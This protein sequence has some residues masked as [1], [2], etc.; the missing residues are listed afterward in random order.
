MGMTHGTIAGMLLTDL[1][2]GRENPWAELYDPSRCRLKAARDFV[3]ENAERRRPVPR[4]G[5]RRAT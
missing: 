1:I 3:K 5:D 4:L 2:L